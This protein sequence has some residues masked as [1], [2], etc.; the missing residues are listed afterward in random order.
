M[1]LDI[2]VHELPMYLGGIR[3]VH[4]V[5]QRF[6]SYSKIVVYIHACMSNSSLAMV[7]HLAITIAMHNYLATYN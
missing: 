7:T 6:H 1:R 2:K 3:F 4:I 5:C